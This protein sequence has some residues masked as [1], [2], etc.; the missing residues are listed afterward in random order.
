[1]SE[2]Q[3][4]L[5]Q[6]ADARID[7]AINK[8]SNSSLL[9][10]HHATCAR[11]LGAQITSLPPGSTILVPA[12]GVSAPQ[13]LFK[14]T[15][16]YL[17]EAQRRGVGSGSG[18]LAP[19][20]VRSEQN[21]KLMRHSLLNTYRA[22]PNFSQVRRVSPQADLCL[23][24][25]PAFRDPFSVV[26][27][28]VSQR[29]STHYYML[30]NAHVLERTTGSRLEAVEH[31]RLITQLGAE[32][33]RTQIL[34]GNVTTLCRWLEFPEVADAVLL[35]PLEPYDITDAE[36]R[37]TFQRLLAT[38]DAELPWQAT[39]PMLDHSEGINSAVSGCPVRLRKWVVAALVYAKSE[40][41]SALTWKHMKKTAP[42][43]SERLAA[44]SDLKNL[45]LI[46]RPL[47]KDAVDKAGK[48][49][50]ARSLERD[51]VRTDAA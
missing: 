38:Y 41:A 13:E 24:S 9:L 21:A 33:R 17:D 15:C 32:S 49:T 48:P 11:H 18:A 12:P 10:P 42:L 36:E 1:M 43:T 2:I 29:V 6:D 44:A 34:V 26:T 30:L 23:Y 14:L 4:T 16:T 47:P 20:T 19:L 31:V 35:S 37:K 39:P 27:T 51:E 46:R 40:G 50:F 22:E 3:L 25:E 5:F 7:A 8:V 45:K 28:L